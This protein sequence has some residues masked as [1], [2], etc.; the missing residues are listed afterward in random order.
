VSGGRAQLFFLTSALEG[1]VWSASRP[2]RLYP[3]KDPVPIVQ[4][5]GWAPEPVWRGA[6]NLTPLGFDPRTLQPVASRYTDYAIPAVQDKVKNE[7]CTRITE[8]KRLPKIFPTSSALGA[9]HLNAQF[10]D[11][12]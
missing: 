6:E 4:E 1:G 3:R 5:A 10:K 2:R 7:N 8:E 11:R 9:V 12:N